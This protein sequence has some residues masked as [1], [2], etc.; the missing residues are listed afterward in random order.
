MTAEQPID[1]GPQNKAKHLAFARK[2]R[3]RMTEETRVEIYGQ[4]HGDVKVWTDEEKA[5]YETKS[6]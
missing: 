3:V 1:F 6:N 4:R 2:D 5:Q